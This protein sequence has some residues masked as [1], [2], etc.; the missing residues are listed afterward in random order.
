ML[1]ALSVQNTTMFIFCPIIGAISDRTTSFLVSIPL[2][3]LLLVVVALLLS[4][5]QRSC[6]P[7]GISLYLSIL[8]SLAFSN[9]F[10]SNW[11]YL[12]ISILSLLKGRRR[13]WII[14]GAILNCCVGIALTFAP[15]LLFFISM[16]SF[17]NVSIEY[18]HI[19]NTRS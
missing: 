1:Q 12:C 16:V 3:L 6:S 7:V 18:I 5:I 17:E 2:F 15:S 11:I 13:P 14:T 9:L 10:N 19:S 8:F 4:L